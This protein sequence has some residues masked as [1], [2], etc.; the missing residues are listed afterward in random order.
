MRAK[1]LG[2]AGGNIGLEAAASAKSSTKAVIVRS[3]RGCWRGFGCEAF[4]A[5]RDDHL[6]KNVMVR[7]AAP[8]RSRSR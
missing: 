2:V 4:Q 7:A 1:R 8:M 5:L 6:A 3:S